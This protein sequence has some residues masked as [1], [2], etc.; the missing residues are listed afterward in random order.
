MADENTEATSTEDAGATTEAG[1][2]QST[3]REFSDTEKRA[4]AQ[5]WVPQDQYE[6]TGKWRD[7]EEFLDRGELFGKIDEQNRR[8]KA[9]EMTMTQLK[10]HYEDVRKN[11]YKEALVSLKA[12]KKAALLDGDADK[13]VEIDDRISDAK[14]EQRRIEAVAQAQPIVEQGP[15]PAFVVWV[16]RNP[17][18]NSDR[19]LQ[20]FANAE[21]DVIVAEGERDP[22][23]VL[24]EVER[25]VK[26]EFAHKFNNPNREKAGAV[27]TGGNK[28]GQRKD[29]FQLS[30]DERRVMKRFVSAGVMTEAQYIADIRESRGA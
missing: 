8:I 24:L 1:T 28:G 20:A 3:E 15:N 22:T 5:G 25:R 7:A 19:A 21:A 14:D 13:V 26:K 4:L 29:S 23:K 30:E 18:Y 27:E 9:Q 12:E 6:G 16:N 17:W 10:K 2:E 11:A